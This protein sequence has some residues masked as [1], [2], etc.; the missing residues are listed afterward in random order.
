MSEAKGFLEYTQSGKGAITKE[1]I[2]SQKE[3]NEI[4]ST[5]LPVGFVDTSDPPA[6]ASR[7][8]TPPPVIP[9]DD[10]FINVTDALQRK[11]AKALSREQTILDLHVKEYLLPLID[12]QKRQNI[13]LDDL[14]KSL[15][16]T[17]EVACAYMLASFISES[18]D[19]PSH[20]SRAA[21]DAHILHQ[22]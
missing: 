3:W 20:C 2:I 5:S 1:V 12:Q 4:P 7:I 13:T 21:I 6:S 10:P 9:S 22:N 8:F 19:L 11:V 15:A 16:S 14:E 18:P 17:G